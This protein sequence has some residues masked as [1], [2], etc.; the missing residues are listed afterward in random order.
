MT[1][2]LELNDLGIRCYRDGEQLHQSPG[3]AIAEKNLVI[4]EQAWQQSRMHPHNTHTEF[5][6]KLN[7]EAVVSPHSK[8]RHHG[9]L[10]YLHLLHIESQLPFDF[11]NQD[12]IYALPSSM[13]REAL[14]LLLGIS[15]QCGINTIGL[16]DHALASMRPYGQ[17]AELWHLEMHLNDSILT[18]LTRT[19]NQLQRQQVEVLK[20][21]GWLQ[22]HTKALQFLS[23]QFIQKT[24]FNPRHNADSE[25]Q[26]F[27]AIPGWIEQS[28]SQPQIH[29][30]I[31]NQQIDVT[32]DQLHGAIRAG[33]PKITNAIASHSNL[34]AGDRLSRWLALFGDNQA[35]EQLTKTQQNSAMA[36]LSRHID[37]H[38][39]GVRL[40]NSL[41]C[42][43]VIETSKVQQPIA[44]HALWKNRAYPLHGLYSLMANGDIITGEV[45]NAA[46]YIQQGKIRAASRKPVING[47]PLNSQRLLT[48]DRIEI[49]G[50]SET[51]ILIE[52]D[53]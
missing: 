49:N 44:T 38:P 14:G 30:D 34:Y 39:E 21:Q 37:S 26:L 12:V 22:A 19:D 20:G 28:F 50:I 53:Q 27:N 25:Q 1:L 15:Q 8:V 29:C 7:T 17:Q 43:D 18:R 24:R 47:K 3:I 51:M 45:A 5:W 16:V 36:S 32:S 10:A 41:P 35:V 40:I 52:V 46:I 6:S 11:K 23:E 31:E 2:L 13:N 42:D 33:L 9:D 4:G 48:G